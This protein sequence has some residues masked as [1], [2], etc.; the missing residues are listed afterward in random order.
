M[1]NYVLILT[2]GES[3]EVFAIH[4]L[5]NTFLKDE[6]MHIISFKTNIYSLYSQ[7]KK[8]DF[9]TDLVEVLKERNAGKDILCGK[10]SINEIDREEISEI[11]LL[12]D[13]DAHHY[14]DNATRSVKE[15]NEL[16]N[17][18]NN[19]TEQG[20]LY[21][22][23]PMIEAINYHN[24]KQEKS[25]QICYF[26]YDSGSNAAGIHFKKIKNE[27]IEIVKKLKS[28][29]YSEDEWI[30]IF[31]QFLLVIH[32]AMNG[33]SYSK[34]APIE[35][36]H[37]QQQSIKDEQKIFVISAIPAMIIEYFG[38][39]FYDQLLSS[40]TFQDQYEKVEL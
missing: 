39:K 19:E 37:A 25:I 2:E 1:S 40:V 30:G 33:V 9:D 22:S 11:Y 6:K 8:D 14:G 5:N 24:L 15:L 4:S 21:L 20:K 23:Y 12:F 10:I 36:F 29:G 27:N 34:I 7:L 3:E 16:I 38:Q 31:K 18:F 13:Y 35:I 17:H 26:P 28:S 32:Y